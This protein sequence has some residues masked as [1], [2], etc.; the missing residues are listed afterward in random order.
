MMQGMRAIEARFE[1][2]LLRPA[3]PLPLRPGERV[4]L[5]VIRRPDPK[6]WDL[7]KLATT[8]SEDLEL[9][10]AGLDEWTKRLDSEDNEDWWMVSNK[11][12]E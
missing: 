6:R 7:D 3:E 8:G 11:A 2:G 5:I 1:D 4:N 10:E 9:A 12:R